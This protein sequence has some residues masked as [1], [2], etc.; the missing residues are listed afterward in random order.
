M[1]LLHILISNIVASFFIDIHLFI[2]VCIY[3]CECYVQMCVGTHVDALNRVQREG[4]EW[5]V[6][7]SQSLI[8]LREGLSL[9]LE[10]MFCSARL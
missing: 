8:P 7:F 3:P 1:K 10:V 2:H 6:L 9:R 5:L 4:V